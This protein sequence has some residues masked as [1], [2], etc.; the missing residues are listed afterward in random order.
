MEEQDSPEPS[1]A[2]AE[3]V[4]L[5]GSQP[6]PTGQVS[7]EVHALLVAAAPAVHS[8]S[9][10]NAPAEQSASEPHPAP[11]LQE[12]M[13][14]AAASAKATPKPHQAFRFIRCSLRRARVGAPAAATMAQ[15]R[16]FALS[17]LTHS[18]PLQTGQMPTGSGH[19]A[20]CP[21]T[22]ELPL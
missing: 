3:Q 18:S 20:P 6:C 9:R 4:R 8:P 22:R 13:V 21:R 11:E 2:A 5:T 7:S 16:A 14:H 1:S 12:A 17:C 19:G 15:R 10:H